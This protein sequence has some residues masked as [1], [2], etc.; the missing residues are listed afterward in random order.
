MPSAEQIT[1]TVHAYLDSAAKGDADRI[2]TLY[3]TDATVE[4]PAGGEVH[5]GRQAIRSFYT[6][7][8]NASSQ[9]DVETLRVLGNEAAFYWT[10]TIHGMAISIISVMTFDADA[11]IATMKAYWGPDNIKT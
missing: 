4:D 1:E 9:A 2:A 6:A 8:E 11:K 5:V 10:L 3:A 7:V